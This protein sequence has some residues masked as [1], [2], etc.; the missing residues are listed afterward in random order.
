MLLGGYGSGELALVAKV[1][2]YSHLSS[3]EAVALRREIANMEVL[4]RYNHP[5]LVRQPS[6]CAIH[7]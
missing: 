3:S 4:G 7:M 1:Q 5:H 6:I 2:P